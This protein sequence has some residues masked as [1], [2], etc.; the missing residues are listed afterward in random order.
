VNEVAATI[1]RILGKE[2]TRHEEPPRAGDIR[3]SWADI[4]AAREALGWEPS[5]ELEEGLRRT[6]EHLV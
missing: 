2:V 1:G 3:N 6:A 5:V 4:T